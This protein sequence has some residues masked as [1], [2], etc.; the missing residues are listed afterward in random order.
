MRIRTT[1]LSLA[2]LSTVLILGQSA[3]H[4]QLA[5]RVSP[6]PTDTIVPGEVV[7]A[8][9]VTTD[10][11]ASVAFYTQVFG[12][13]IRRGEDPG[14]IELAHNGDAICAVAKFDDDDVT[15]G[16]ARW[17]VSISVPDVDEVV[18]KVENRGG[19]VLEPADDFPDRGRFAVVSDS[20]GAVFMLLRASG[21]DPTGNKHVAG[22][23]GW[24]ELWARDVEEAVAFYQEVI[25]YRAVRM[26]GD[27]GQHPVV[28]V[29]EK[30][31][32]ATVVGIPWD[33]V[34]PN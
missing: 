18:E 23:W 10:V 21:G 8:D 34:E 24:A 20:Q 16:N 4:A 12:W 31:P 14:Y 13:E 9:L 26:P 29:T 30:T 22:A 1:L 17:L 32:R 5:S 25:G 19:S 3:A 28:L 2:L 33:N 15:P 27:N 7:W 6:A 11:E